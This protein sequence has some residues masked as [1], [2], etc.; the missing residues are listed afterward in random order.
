[1]QVKKQQLELDMEQQTLLV[2][3]SGDLS[4]HLRPPDRHGHHVPPASCQHHQAA[5]VAW[6]G[7]F[8]LH[9][10]TFSGGRTLVHASYAVAQHQIS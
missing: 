9:V 5:L 8:S 4:F 1:M 2:M 7:H 3:A 10:E 6:A